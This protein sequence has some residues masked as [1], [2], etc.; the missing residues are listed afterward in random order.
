MSERFVMGDVDHPFIAKLYSTFKTAY[1]L[2][3]VL[4][5]C[6]G[7][8]LF[9]YMQRLD[10]LP[11][12]EARFYAASVASA[13]EHLHTRNVIYRDLKPE[14]V[15]IDKE[16]NNTL[17]IIDFGTSTIYDKNNGPLKTTH[18]TSYYIAPEVFL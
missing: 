8:E 9:S 17:K 6:L 13:L 18:G 11:E 2:F 16:L 12:R 4:E 7:G 1:S 3:M 5:P 10:V 14:N 15:L